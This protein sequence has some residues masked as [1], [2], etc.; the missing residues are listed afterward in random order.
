MTNPN[1]LGD[2]SAGLGPVADVANAETRVAPVQTPG[3]GGWTPA[4]WVPL[5]L[6]VV[7]GAVVAV[8]GLLSGGG[9]VTVGTVIGALL[10]G[11]GGGAA[12]FLGVKSAG[13]RKEQGQ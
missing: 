8:G 2:G 11:A 13:P 6:S 9:V 5:V 12:T 3:A 10:T 7:V 1:R 4:A